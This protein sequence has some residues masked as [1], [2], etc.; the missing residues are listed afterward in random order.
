MAVGRFYAH[1]SWETVPM[2]T[3]SATGKEKDID[4]PTSDGRPMAETEVHLR[5]ML[6]LI[7][8]LTMRYLNDPRVYVAGNMFLYY[9]RG[10]WLKHV[11]PDVFVVKGVDKHLRDYYKVWE[12]GDK[13]PDLVIE[14]TS[15]STRGEDIEDKFAIYQDTLKIPEYF[16][17]DPHA[18][19][20]KPPLKGYRLRRGRYVQIKPVEKRLPSEVLGLHLERDDWRLRL[21]D[22]AA[23]QWLLPPRDL[24]AQEQ[25]A[26]QQAE[27]AIVREKTARQQAEAEVERLR[28]ELEDLRRGPS[29][30]Q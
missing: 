29:G 2:A 25:A 26:R 18:E 6:D 9:V 27:A 10:D 11:S 28:R 24:L 8:I 17:F 21:Y 4:Y 20:L 16:L 5:N 23:K 15:R 12:E 3:R 19:Y 30:E 7:F 22:P 13:V 14:L 1:P